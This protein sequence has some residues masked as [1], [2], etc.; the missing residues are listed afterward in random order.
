MEQSYGKLTHWLA[1]YLCKGLGVK[2][3]LA[4]AE[5]VPLENLVDLSY[6]QLLESGLNQQVATN[7]VATDWQLVA[8]YENLLFASDIEVISYFDS[9]YPPLLKQIAS[10]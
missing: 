3:L 1:F 10:A 2:T 6:Q 8:H 5:K 9:R 4:L 7:L